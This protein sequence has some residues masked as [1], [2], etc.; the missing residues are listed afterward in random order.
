ME[1]LDYIPLFETRRGAIQESLHFGAVAVVASDGK[2]IASAGDP[3]MTTFLR[4]TAKPFQA[5]P[6]IEQGGHQHW[7]LNLKEI[8]ILCASHTGTNDHVE[9]VRGIQAKIGIS[10]EDLQCGI[11]WP[12][13]KATRK[14]MQSRGEKPNPLHHNCSG[15]HTGMLALAKMQNHS[16]DNYLEPEHPVQKQILQTFSEM[17]MLSPED[18]I[19]GIDG[20][21]APNF[22]IPLFHAAWGLARLADPR[23]L[24]AGRAKACRTITT[25]MISHPEMIS[26]PERFDT[27]LIRVGGGKLFVKGGAEGY[28]GIG[29]MPGVRNP[30]SPG[31]GIVLKISDGDGQKRA[32][33]AVSLEILKQLKLLSVPQ[34]EELSSFG[35]GT[36]IRNRRELVVGEG[37]PVFSLDIAAS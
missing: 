25:A 20:C 31:L 9:T 12:A 8:A 15:K 17:G 11:H 3:D 13:D 7:Q 23:D 2:L 1:R 10:E 5:L 6:L 36:M 24:P 37:N 33:P 21:S 19:V 18:V 4:S 29:I 28:L 32:R 22:A 34:L 26:G 30:H 35:P 27:R 16:L 14:A